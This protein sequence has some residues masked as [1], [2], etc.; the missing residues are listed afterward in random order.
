[1]ER[2]DKILNTMGGIYRKVGYQKDFHNEVKRKIIAQQQR[3]SLLKVLG[4]ILMAFV[5][6]IG[7][8]S[9][10]N[11]NYAF[12]GR[13]F[14]I[15]IYIFFALTFAIF[16]VAIIMNTQNRLTKIIGKNWMDKI[17]RDGCYFSE[18]ENEENNEEKDYINTKRVH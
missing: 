1:M 7:I 14:A 16:I 18:N 10:A 6:F 9:Y 4:T 15:Y 12:F 13:F 11:V 5:I 3:R 8:L 2:L 17:K